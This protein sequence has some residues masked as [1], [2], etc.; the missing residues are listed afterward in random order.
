MAFPRRKHI[1]KWY[2]FDDWCQ[3][4]EGQIVLKAVH[5]LFCQRE[6]TF[7]GTGFFPPQASHLESAEVAVMTTVLQG[8]RMCTS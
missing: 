7:S 2:Y 4:C 5:V 6:A 1:G 8:M 3:L